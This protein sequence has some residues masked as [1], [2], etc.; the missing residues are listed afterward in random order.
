[1]SSGSFPAICSAARPTEKK[2]ELSHARISSVEEW[3]G[4]FVSKGASS[5][6]VQLSEPAKIALEKCCRVL[7]GNVLRHDS[8]P[9]DDPQKTRGQSGDNGRRV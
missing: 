1:M 7:P 5:A 6:A 9:R 8:V 3:S 4:D 2:V